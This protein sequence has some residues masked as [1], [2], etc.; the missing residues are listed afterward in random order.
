MLKS[1]QLPL[2]YLSS[3]TQSQACNPCIYPL[4]TTSLYHGLSWEKKN[5]LKPLKKKSMSYQNASSWPTYII[6]TLTSNIIQQQQW[7]KTETL[8]KIISG[9]S[10]S[11]TRAKGNP[12]RLS[13]NKHRSS[14][15]VSKWKYNW[16]WLF[17]KK[18][19]MKPFWIIPSTSQALK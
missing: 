13:Y 3:D 11:Q 16:G 6:R 1:Q 5:L 7:S 8:W 2:W 18:T 4:S 9:A 14:M 15:R 12:Y 10:P 17:G 19:K